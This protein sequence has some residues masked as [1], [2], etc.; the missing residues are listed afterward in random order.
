MSDRDAKIC[1]I[2]D[3]TR[4][5]N[6]YIEPRRCRGAMCEWYDNVDAPSQ[7]A[8]GNNEKKGD[9]YENRIQGTAQVSRARAENRAEKEQKRRMGCGAKRGNFRIWSASGTG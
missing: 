6:P 1:P 3:A 7:K 9:K 4:P 8:F 2:A 5:R